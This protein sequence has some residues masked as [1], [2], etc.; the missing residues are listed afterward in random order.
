MVEPILQVAFPV[1]V[2]LR[3]AIVAA[4]LTASKTG[5]RIKFWWGGRSVEIS[6]GDD[7]DAV[8]RLYARHGSDPVV[9]AP[10]GHHPV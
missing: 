4:H 9:R 6:Y 5:C 3:A 8:E 10:A 1:G 2:G 7:L